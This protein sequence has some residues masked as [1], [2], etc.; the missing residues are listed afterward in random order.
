M[1]EEPINSHFRRYWF[2]VV[3]RIETVLYNLPVI[4]HDARNAI[5]VADSIAKANYKTLPPYIETVTRGKE[6]SNF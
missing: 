2:D 6:I 4:A 1:R 3:Y 5:E